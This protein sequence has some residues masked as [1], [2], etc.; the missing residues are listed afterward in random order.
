MPEFDGRAE[1]VLKHSRALQSE[2]RELAH[3]LAEAGREIRSKVDL[4][5]SVQAHPFRAVL[6]GVGVGYVLGGGL[7]SP[8]TRQLLRLGSRA[9][10]VPLV[11]GQ[12]ESMLV[13]EQPAGES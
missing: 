13:G 4:S 2:A 7:F 10:I 8:L 9:L 6:I 3:D 5:R 1:R 11:R 12:I